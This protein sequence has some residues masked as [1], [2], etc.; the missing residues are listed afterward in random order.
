MVECKVS[1][2]NYLL[3]LFL[4]FISYSISILTNIKYFHLQL[5]VLGNNKRTRKLLILT[6]DGF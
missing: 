2:K 3:K 6:S 5:S 1:L 4:N